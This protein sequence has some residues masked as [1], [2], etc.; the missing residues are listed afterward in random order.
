LMSVAMIQDNKQIVS[1]FVDIT[2]SKK[3]EEEIRKLNNELDQRVRER[4]AQLEASNKEMEA[5]SYS[6]SHD[7]RSPLRH[8]S[9]FVNL[10]AGQLNESHSE[11]EKHYINVISDSTR[12]MGI[13]IDDLL[14]FSRSGR[15]E[16]NLTELDMNEILQEAL[17]IVKH[18]YADRNIDWAISPLP[19]VF[20]DH[21][22]LRMVWV[23]LLS[24]AV[25]F[26]RTKVKAR[27]ESGFREKNNELVFYLRD[28]GA[29]FDM[30]YIEKL[31]GVFQRLHSVEEYEGTGIGLA[32][33][34]RI[35]GK[36]GGRTW[37]E[38]EI[39]KGATFYFTIPK[40]ASGTKK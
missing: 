3:A 27:I 6:V 37:A 14:E 26:T 4:T 25:K 18:D 8:I 29:G 7:L 35:I 24:N 21:N 15:Q 5:F 34:H 17:N 1:S 31:F 16:I 20:G 30:Q 12:Q 33:V 40:Q 32:N 19:R 10:L 13:L 2:N 23:N 11:K 22:L 9:G 39:G 28:N 38:G 36:H